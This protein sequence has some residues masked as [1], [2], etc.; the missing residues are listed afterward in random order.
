MRIALCS[1]IV[2]DRPVAFRVDE[3]RLGN[4]GMQGMHSE[5]VRLR[6]RYSWR[7]HGKRVRRLAAVASTATGGADLKRA[8]VREKALLRLRAKLVRANA[9][10]PKARAR[11]SLSR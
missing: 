8:L 6:Q 5:I 2:R 11:G 10:V 4:S 9:V 7:A 3:Q 1:D